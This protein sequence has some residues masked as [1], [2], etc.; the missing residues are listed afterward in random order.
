MRFSLLV[1]IKRVSPGEDVPRRLGAGTRDRKRRVE[2]A[3]G[4]AAYILTLKAAAP[5]SEPKCKRMWEG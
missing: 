3:R 4:P 2:G 5:R 1:V